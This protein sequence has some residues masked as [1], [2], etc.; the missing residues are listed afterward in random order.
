MEESNKKK[1]IKNAKKPVIKKKE[2]KP[3]N[4]TI[5]KKEK[6][7]PV[8]IENTKKTIEKK[9]EQK[10]N[11]IKRTNNGFKNFKE[12]PKK[13][14]KEFFLRQKKALSINRLTVIFVLL[15]SINGLLLRALTMGNSTIF[16]FDAFLADMLFAIF[17]AAF[18]YLFNEKGRFIYLEIALIL[19]SAICVLNSAYYTF[20]TSF[21]SIS[22]LSTARFI[23]D[24]GDA[25]VENVLQPKDL[26]YIIAPIIFIIIRFR[27]MKKDSY[28][29]SN[30]MHK[31]KKSF[32]KTIII[33][34]F[35]ALAFMTTLTG[36]DVSRLTKQWNREYVVKKFGIYIY[37][38]NDFIKSVEPKFAALFGYDSALKE[39][40]DFYKDVEGPV[41][42]EFT[43]MFE[44]K[45][46]LVIHGESI[47]NFLIGLEFNGEEVTP[48]LNK[49]VKEGMYFNN[50]YT[51]VS[52]GT[53]SDTEFTFNTSLM[54][55]SIGTAFSDYADK[56]YVSIPKLLKE[57]G[58][59]SFAMH[60]NNGEYWNRR[61]MHHNLGYDDLIAKDQYEI[62]EVIGLG[63]SDMSFFRQSIP[64]LK[65]IQ[66]SHQN[67]YGTI[68]MLTNHTPF[69]ETDKYGEFDVDIK[70][71]ITNANGQKEVISHPYMEGTK[72]GN[73]FKSV[74]YAD[75]ALGYFF[76]ELEKNGLLENTVI[77][78]YGDHDARLPQSDYERLYNY[79][80]TTDTV[81]D[82][83]DPLYYDFNDYVYELNRKVPFVIW[84]KDTIDKAT[85]YDY[86]MGMYDAM[87]TIG[88]MFGFYNKYALGHD[89][90]NTKYDNLVIFPTGNWLT[91]DMYYNNQREE[92]YYINNTIISNETIEYNCELTDK[93]L[94]TSNN[95]LVYDL[96]K[97]S[98]AKVVN[99][100]NLIKE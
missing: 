24:V 91:K 90:F 18:G 53:S 23:T 7:K 39:F 77:I 93:I 81:R 64:K 55:A 82:K 15:V 36:T 54:P 99:E 80:P 96:I 30:Y 43:G 10:L 42:N 48:N 47:Q 63:L 1:N 9:K 66:E 3:I 76:E 26:I 78:F 16:N 85:T 65:E 100:N 58:Y 95:I 74:H 88:N 45:N 92:S 49:F 57:Q 84:S 34:I 11:V 70:E 6:K 4:K 40:N 31:S 27:Y 89:I 79:D 50:F 12:N 73:Y 38:I 25:V 75:K 94:T 51:Q 5:V 52:I 20:Y 21:S 8:V 60:A 83:D 72:L 56:E 68:I 19:L 61:I 13:C 97:N 44:G 37:H 41:T 32:S 98:K 33:G 71:T 29:K 62:D 67:Y 14:I 86:P 69:S 46:I 17:V 87:P 2:K 59:Y 35:C 22:L 28:L